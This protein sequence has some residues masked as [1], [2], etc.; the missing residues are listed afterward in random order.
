M[1]ISPAKAKADAKY[2]KK[3]YN[4]IGLIFRKDSAVNLDIIRAYAKE[5]GES[6]NGF[7]LRAIEETIE[8]DKNR[9]D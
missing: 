8:R 2:K 4:R 6:L 9:K 1:P 5:C 3:T 7:L